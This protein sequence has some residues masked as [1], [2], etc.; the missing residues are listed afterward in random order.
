M[1]KG[2]NGVYRF[3]SAFLAAT[4]VFF[5][6]AQSALA[7][8]IEVVSDSDVEY[9][10]SLSP[11]EIEITDDYEE[12][13]YNNLPDAEEEIG[14][15]E[16]VE[17]AEFNADS[18]ITSYTVTFNKEISIDDTSITEE[19]GIANKSGKYYL[20]K[21]FST[22][23]L[24]LK[25]ASGYIP[26][27]DTEGYIDFTVTVGGKALDYAVIDY[28]AY[29]R[30]YRLVFE[31]NE[32][33]DGNYIYGNV[34]I[35][36]NVQTVSNCKTITWDSKLTIEEDTVPDGY[37]ASA[38]N[39]FY[40]DP[41]ADSV[42]VD[43][44]LDPAYLFDVDED[45][46][47][48]IS[49]TLG[50]K[51]LSSDDYTAIF[52]DGSL[53]FYLS[54][55]M[56]DEGNAL[57]GNI[58]I[59]NKIIS[60]KT[61]YTFSYSGEAAGSLL[62]DDESIDEESG[63][64]KDGGKYFIRRNSYDISADFTT[65]DGY[66]PLINQ[67]P[68]ADESYY[69]TV[70]IGGK[71]ISS[72]LYDVDIIPKADGHYNISVTIY[73]VDE[74]DKELSGDIR[75][76]LR[77]T[78]IRTDYTFTYSG[79]AAGSLSMYTEEDVDDGN[80]YSGLI[81]ESGKYYIKRYAGSVTA[82]FAIAKGYMPLVNADGE[83]IYSVTIGEKK[84]SSEQYTVDVQESYDDSPSTVSVDIGRYD[85]NEKEINGNIKFVI[86]CGK[87]RT[88]YTLSLGNNLFITEDDYKESDGLEYENGKYYIKRYAGQISVVVSAKPGYAIETYEDENGEHYKQVKVTM[89]GKVVPDTFCDIYCRG[90]DDL[91]LSIDLTGDDE[92][93]APA[94]GN[95]SLTATTRPLV[96]VSLNYNKDHV[97]VINS[98][99]AANRTSE[100]N[101]FF[102][103]DKGD[104]Y[105]YF[106]VEPNLGYN[107][108]SVE[109]DG[110]ILE[111]LGTSYSLDEI[112]K[113]TTITI[114]S[115]PKDDVEFSSKVDD[116]A[117]VSFTGVK[118][119]ASGKTLTD[120]SEI[121]A[122]VTPKFGRQI[123][124][125]S[126]TIGSSNYFFE[127]EENGIYTIK[128]EDVLKAIEEG[129]PISF[130]VTTTAIPVKVNC[131]VNG[132]MEC[133]GGYIC[134]S[135]GITFDEDGNCITNVPDAN[136][137]Y[138]IS[139]ETP[140]TEDVIFHSVSYKVGKKAEVNFAIS[141]KD[142][143]TIPSDAVKAAL[144]AQEEISIFVSF[145]QEKRKLTVVKTSGVTLKTYAPGSDVGNNLSTGEVPYLSNVGFVAV[146][147]KETARKYKV[148]SVLCDN[149]PMT[150]L[151]DGKITY[152]CIERISDPHTISVTLAPI[153]KFVTIKV[154]G[155]SHIDPAYA[156]VGGRP[157]D[158]NSAYQ[159]IEF[160]VPEKS[161]VTIKADALDYYTLSSAKS[162]SGSKLT[163]K[164]GVVTLTATKDDQIK[165]ES[166]G[167]THVVLTDG[168][169]T[170]KYVG[171]A[172]FTMTTDETYKLK[173][174]K[175]DDTLKI[176][177]LS[178]KNAPKGST[179]AKLDDKND[180]ITFSGKEAVGATKDIAV[181]ISAEGEKK[182]LDISFTVLKKPTTVSLKGFKKNKTSQPIGTTASYAVTLNKGANYED[183]KAKI[184]SGSNKN[185][186]VSYDAEK[187]LL[188]VSTF[189]DKT[190]S[191]PETPV[192]IQFTDNKG[193]NIGEVFT[194]EPVKATLPA[195]TA[196]C[197]FISDKKMT[198]SLSAPKAASGYANLY[199][200]IQAQPTDK[201]LAKQVGDS[202]IT[203]VPA[204]ENS[205]S[206]ELPKSAPGL[207]FKVKVTTVQIAGSSANDANVLVLGK[208]SSLTLT[209]K[210]PCYEKKLSLTKKNASY[211]MYQ[212]ETVLATAKFSPTTTYA[213]LS[214]VEVYN[215]KKELV[216]PAA[217]GS[218][219]VYVAS[220]G[221]TIEAR[222]TS[223][224]LPGTYTLKA[225]AVAENDMTPASA[226][227][228]F[229]VKAPVTGISLTPFTKSLYKAPGKAASLK[230]KAECMSVINKTSY[231]PGN[232]KVVWNIEAD[233]ANLASAIKINA[234]G[235]V[236]IDKS[237]VLSRYDDENTFTVTA[238]ATDLEP[239]N[240]ELS[241]ASITVTLTD[242]KVTPTYV[243]IVGVK[244][245][246]AP[247]KA[248]EVTNSRIV[249]RD[250]NMEVI[251]L[252]TLDISIA[253]KKG[254]LIDSDGYITV[255]APGT[256]TITFTA[257]DGS[258]S[259]L[260]QKITVSK[261]QKKKK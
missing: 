247:H 120:H 34:V 195:P 99:P 256:Y 132:Q 142:E 83:Y 202:L 205:F 182:A 164:N 101:M 249:V 215:D 193:N 13:D 90:E 129:L 144:D 224:L 55:P 138:S 128:K 115:S 223:A 60:W 167:I 6:C 23:F 106:D 81:K 104:K 45:Y 118:K 232:A 58:V 127:D 22:F 169:T 235:S 74:N 54:F 227:M 209:T 66:M 72:D 181:S 175:G 112:T 231:K 177:K 113:D 149:E 70:T 42:R 96:K 166:V 56:D 117:T 43:L 33:D 41:A 21:N 8:D 194:V 25:L 257:R 87:T 36:L 216:S 143:Y 3:L 191:K 57:Q 67:D 237:Y 243:T 62:I 18:D 97:T 219:I 230:L 79:E 160:E 158:C 204:S 77:C 114:K 146:L 46:N 100:D 190:L 252:D 255:T 75:F 122:T 28:D 116:G 172:G 245:L 246:S 244:N 53:S 217:D 29:T 213:E 84:L 157:V 52:Y 73:R 93:K 192:L 88:D 121:I 196:K 184:S 126:C 206:Y 1:K 229:T 105:F 50:G 207:K 89:G 208:S 85:E 86:K 214:K 48:I 125:V 161:V 174:K 92:N 176:A 150:A 203:F 35:K 119:G 49:V 186:T 107:L 103:V 210:A 151:V 32:G 15:V 241:E 198:L 168:S 14:E 9:T 11:E 211:T 123:F 12:A 27:Y 130:E 19:S 78:K 61:S 180:S 109:Q 7:T 38:K 165:L 20:R 212:N 259:K 242:E 2:N 82:K 156:L 17:E 178:V 102:Y 94:L 63:L 254:L 137:D 171:K 234:N 236:T 4:T 140:H 163:V 98:D 201:E 233:N 155:D 183:V 222:K 251:D 261:E 159:S 153:A 111:S 228:K 141:E 179:F 39:G 71:K 152:Y 16:M 135:S 170:A 187:K 5:S 185:A 68:E 248:E 59:T 253:P 188:T 200:K 238:T 95:I 64:I 136:N 108:I 147:D 258:G 51:K 24:G 199:Y 250:E 31:L 220:D 131:Y 218:H 145:T 40:I 124:D 134:I 80:F 189:K 10:S 133:P 226:E 148:E 162:E 197:S 240:M 139:F 69:A 154:V 26:K 37:I 173:V 76:V 91:D 47:E 221:T 110:K 239:Y 44:A 225:Y 65:A 30:S 260:S